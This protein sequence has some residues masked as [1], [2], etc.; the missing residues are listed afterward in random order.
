MY[1]N[2]V[3]ISS[4][5]LIENI[6]Q[7]RSLL[8]KNTQIIAVIKANAYGHG[9]KEIAKLA[10]P[11]VDYFQV[12]D[13]EEFVELREVSQKPTFIFGYVM[14]KDL[15]LMVNLNGI[16]GLYSI[17]QAVLLDEI[18]KSHSRIVPV[19]I[20]VDSHLGRDGILASELDNFLAH[21]HTLSNIKIDG[22][23]SH[24]ANIEDT[25]D[26]THANKQIQTFEQ[27][28]KIFY[29]YGYTDIKSHISAT[30]G[31]L[32]YEQFAYHNPLVRLGIGMYG[33]WP[34]EGLRQKYSS[35]IKLQP[36]MTVKSIIAQ[37]KTLPKGHSVGYGLTYITH[38]N[39]K[40]GIVPFGYSD[41]IPRS[42]SNQG[43]VLVKGHKCRIIGRISMNMMTIDLDQI[44]VT[45]E[46]EV[47]ILGSQGSATITAEDIAK[48]HETINYEI[49]ANINP[50]LK[51]V[52]I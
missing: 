8:P 41:G 10:E 40:V 34:S 19:H 30:S 7:F 47:V 16:L 28:K 49:L 44:D 4:Q 37:I 22:F 24:F 12:D 38:K 31:I 18:G 35:K 52:I 1:H 29:Q 5:N 51:R 36:V 33:L 15:E 21:I 27:V 9:L 45:E 17:R 6:K 50:K 2:V 14:E 11:Y 13:I 48:I 43:Y 46:S 3:E 39:M 42:L 25:D 23:Y 26:K 20:C 32:E